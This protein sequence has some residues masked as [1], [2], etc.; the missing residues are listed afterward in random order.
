M[1]NLFQINLFN[2]NKVPICYLIDTLKHLGGAEMHLFNL[3]RSLDRD[4]FDPLVLTLTKGGRFT[5]KIRS[6]GIRLEEVQINRIYT[7]AAIRPSIYMASILKEAKVKII[8]TFHFASDML[9]PLLAEIANVPIVVSSRRDMGFKKKCY[10]MWAYR[11]INCFVDKIIVNSRAVRNS[12]SI[13]EKITPKKMI[14]IYNGVNLKSFY[15]SVDKNKKLKEQLGLPFQCPIVGM[16]ANLHPIKG[17]PDFLRAACIILKKIINTHFLIVG[18]GEMK[19]E[20]E[21]T[22]VDLGIEGNVHFLGER[23]DIPAILSIIDVSV[24]SSYSEGFSNTILESMAMGK[25]VVATRVGGNPEIISHGVNGYLIEPNAPRDLAK[26]ILNLL[27]DKAL[28]RLMGRN[29]R[30]TVEKHFN[31]EKM[32]EEITRLY[33]ELLF[34]VNPNVA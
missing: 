33:R 4:V 26:A 1:T 13:Q 7:P 2:I 22:A 24:L 29:G 14:T 6:L 30:Q 25:P 16:I 32:V 5:N 27:Y 15:M 21:K 10:H 3:I 23:A 11:L 8:Q 20:L 9:G 12:V 28:A 34:E 31:E 19:T 17:Y 18:D